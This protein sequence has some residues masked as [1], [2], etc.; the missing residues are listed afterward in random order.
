MKSYN[1]LWNT[2]ISKENIL[3]SVKNASKGKKNLRIKSLYKNLTNPETADLYFN[4]IVY[5]VNDFKPPSHIP[6]QIIDGTS[7]K[8]RYIVVPK[9]YEKI[10][11][12][13]LV[14]TLKP[15]FLKG[16]YEYCFTIGSRVDGRQTG[17]VHGKK[18][19]EHWT[20]TAG[21]DMDYCLK[22]DIKHFFENIKTENLKKK[23]SKYIKDQKFKEFLFNILDAIPDELGQPLGFYLSQWTSDWYLQDLDH[24][25]KEK[26]HVKYYA[27]FRDD[28][29]CFSSDK[30][31]LHNVR[32]EV[33]KFLEKEGLELNKKWQVFKF[34]NRPL[35]FMGF[36]F[37]RDKTVL[38][39]NLLKR[40]RRVGNKIVNNSE[41]FTEKDA[42]R[43]ISYAGWFKH[44]D[45]YNYYNDY[46]K[47]TININ[48]LKNKIG[49]KL[50][51]GGK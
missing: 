8:V 29:V 42:K 24:F 26:L 30:E 15:L 28:M 31:F 21:R 22:M 51:N 4:K 17:Q 18:V 20:K 33:S 16:A 11:H 6:K 47:Q 32:K 9:T 40:A 27:R 10:I 38:R 14:N 44:S 37:Y 50:Q 12:H 34:D 45:T 48:S 25:I 5:I 36:K 41:T 49:G 23:L 43:F 35:D 19:I 39:K 13:M 46:V 3:L 7:R 1:N 2:F